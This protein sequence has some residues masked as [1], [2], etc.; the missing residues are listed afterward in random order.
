ME[1]RMKTSVCWWNLFQTVRIFKNGGEINGPAVSN[2]DFLA[3]IGQCQ[4]DFHIS[5][6]FN[7]H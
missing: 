4:T 5:F 1:P 3:F 2:S 6:V 7:M